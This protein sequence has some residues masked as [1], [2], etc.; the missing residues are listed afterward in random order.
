GEPADGRPFSSVPGFNSFR[1]VDILEHVESALGI[2]VPAG[3]LTADTLR[4]AG[5][6]RDLALRHLTAPAGAAGG[7]R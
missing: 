3:D 1:M 2:E 6:L 4:D 7:G 5:T